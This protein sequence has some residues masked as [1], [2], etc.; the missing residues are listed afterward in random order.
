MKNSY[1][2]KFYW[3]VVADDNDMAWDIRRTRTKVIQAFA[4]RDPGYQ[5][6]WRRI[7]KW[8]THPRIVRVTVTWAKPIPAKEKP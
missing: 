3:A 6:R 1:C 2:D 4:G 8:S 7:K 5:M